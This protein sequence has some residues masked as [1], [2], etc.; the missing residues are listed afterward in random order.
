MDAAGRRNSQQA[1]VRDQVFPRSM[2][3][4]FICSTDIAIVGTIATWK[5]RKISIINIKT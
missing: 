5:E 2:Q 1:D 3:L 4:Q